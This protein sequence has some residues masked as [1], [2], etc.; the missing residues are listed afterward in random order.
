[1]TAVIKICGG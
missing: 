1:G